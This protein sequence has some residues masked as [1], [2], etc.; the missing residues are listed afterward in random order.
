MIDFGLAKAISGMRLTEQSL[1]TAFGSVAGTPL[2]MAPE[3]ASFN[4]LDI[5]TRADIYA[6]GVI[7][8][9]L[10]TGSTPIARETI[11]QAALDEMLRVIREVEPPT[12]SSRISTSE[13]LPTLAANRQVEPARLSRLVRG[14]LDWIVMKALAKE[15]ERR[16]ASAVGLA[17]DV[18]RYLN[19][20]PVSAGPPTAAYRLRKF[21]RRNR[22]QVAAAALVLLALVLGVV[23]TTLGL[24]EARQ[25]A[26]ASGRLRPRHS[27]ERAGRPRSG[28][29]RWR[30]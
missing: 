6:L 19:H 11:R 23:G 5:D 22:V 25:T 30:R 29:R 28:W 7:L 9:E 20:E 3:Q 27:A 2:Y 12:P 10:L 15:R 13:A 26:R 14:D 21:V 4:A 1:F 16:Y 18:E 24:I 8:Y 17:D